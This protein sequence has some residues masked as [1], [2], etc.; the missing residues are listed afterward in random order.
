V[1]AAVM[2]YSRQSA[3]VTPLLPPLPSSTPSIGAPPAL[4]APPV[5]RAEA[6]LP[7]QPP[8]PPASPLKAIS[9]TRHKRAVPS[10]EAETKTQAP[11]RGIALVAVVDVGAS[12]VPPMATSPSA[13]TRSPPWRC[14]AKPASAATPP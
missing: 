13:S 4:P 14:G 8:L 3:S 7:T 1:A 5:L 2:P 9:G 10:I 11:C 6:L 12:E